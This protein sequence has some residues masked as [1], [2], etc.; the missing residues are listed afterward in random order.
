MIGIC[1]NCEKETNLEFIKRNEDILVRNEPINVNV[2]FYKC[3]ECNA[4]FR[5]PKSSDDP[6]DKA[7]REYR[8]IHK[9]NL[10]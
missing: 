4:E 8:R 5:D 10:A 6:L 7:Y 3:S 2:E 1:P 9:M